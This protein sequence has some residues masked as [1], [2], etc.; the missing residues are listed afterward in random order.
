M[1]LFDNI[2]EEVPADTEEKIVGEA[3]ET[4]DPPN[5]NTVPQKSIK[6]LLMELGRLL[7]VLLWAI[8]KYIIRWIYKSIRF[9]IR[10]TRQGIKAIGVW[11]RD[12]STQEKVRTLRRKT[13][14]YLKAFGRLIIHVLRLCLKYIVLGI[15][16][17]F[18]GLKWLAVNLVQFIIHMRPT[19]KRWRMAFKKWRIRAKRGRRLK[20][21]RRQRR[22]EAFKRGGG[23]RGALERKTAS[24]KTS[25]RSYMEEDQEDATPYAITEDDIIKENFEQLESDNKAQAIS[26]K[27]FSSIKNIVEE[28][29]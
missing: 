3:L 13:K 2:E 8:L 12:K 14:V 9:A 19:L 24:L 1:D 16:Y 11:W 29:N 21:I 10:L 18:K 4:Q 15:I 27:F 20:A 28:D 23:L 25:I 5:R 6:E 17:L 22:R 7:L 26:R